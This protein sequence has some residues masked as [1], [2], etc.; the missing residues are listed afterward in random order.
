MKVKLTKDWA[1]YSKG[2][3]VE[4][5]DKSVIKKGFEIKLFEGKEPKEEVVEDPKA[6]E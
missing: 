2:D 5:T 6:D 4:V 3:T 1:D